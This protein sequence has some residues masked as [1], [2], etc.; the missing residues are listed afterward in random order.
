MTAS[1]P[2]VPARLL[3][4]FVAEAVGYAETLREIMWLPAADRDTAQMLRAARGMRGSAT[5]VRLSD[6]AVV[7]GRIERIARSLHTRRIP[8]TEPLSY[9]LQAV[10]YELPELISAGGAWGPGESERAAAI[11]DALHAFVPA[12]GKKAGSMVV[13]IARLFHDDSGPHV[14]YVAVTPQTQFEQQL[15]EPAPVKG[16]GV[17]ARGERPR[18]EPAATRPVPARAAHGAPAPASLRQR[19]PQSPPPPAAPPQ[20]WPPAGG[21]RTPPRGRD[22]QSLISEGLAGFEGMELDSTPAAAPGVLVPIESLLYSGRAALARA[23]EIRA[24]QAAAAREPTP[25]ELDELMD[26]MELA[27]SA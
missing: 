15:R 8:W 11:A 10:L 7:A 26:L 6:L 12:E 14:I 9:S 21:D 19:V 2:T 25:E 3:E 17:T 22:L 4:F 24:A 5:M 16:D 18:A 20:P 23:R 27:A 1:A 13:P